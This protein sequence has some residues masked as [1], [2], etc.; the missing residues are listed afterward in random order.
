M[1]VN[2]EPTF[3]NV[4]CLSNDPKFDVTIK[5]KDVEIERI[6]YKPGL[7]HHS[8]EAMSK[9]MAVTIILNNRQAREYKCD[10]MIEEFNK[11]LLIKDFEQISFKMEDIKTIYVR[12]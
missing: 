1:F 8:F 9:G 7:G 11:L 6:D 12:K 10:R 2:F 4:R 3:G 5:S